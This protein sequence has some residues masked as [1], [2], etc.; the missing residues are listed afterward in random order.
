MIA[1]KSAWRMS[2]LPLLAALATPGTYAASV[3]AKNKEGNRLF[4][5]GKYQDAEKAYVDAQLEAPGR[6]ELLYNLGNTLIKEKRFEPAIQSL[7]QA[8]GKAERGLQANSWYNLG[9]ALFESGNFQDAAQSFIQALRINPSDRDAKRNLELTLRRLKEQKQGA[10]GKSSE[11]DRQKKEDGKQNDQN[12]NSG[13]QERKNDQKQG[14]PEEQNSRE[15]HNQ[16]PAAAERRDGSMSKDRALQILDA[17]KD[18]E[19]AEQRKLQE[20]QARHKA[21]G[22]DW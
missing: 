17:L 15:Q 18:Q 7:R 5:Q 1:A 22:R 13:Q 12:A 8:V 10:S 3:A 21:S 14:G 20:R 16:Q 2:M 19:L 4:Q 11:T 9:N 6:P